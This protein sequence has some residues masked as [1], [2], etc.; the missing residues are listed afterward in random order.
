MKF[1][2]HVIRPI[3][4]ILAIAPMQVFGWGQTGHRVVGQIAENHLNPEA[5]KA[6]KALLGEE[7]LAMCANWMD[8][9]KSNDAYDHMNPW[10]YCTIPDGLSYHT[11]E[12]PDEGDVIQAI[13]HLIV[14]IETKEFQYA[15]NE[16]MAVKMLAHLV[17][18]LH[19]PLHVG[20]GTDKGG[21]DFKIKWFGDYSN[22]HRIW[23]S[24]L[25]NHQQLS[26]TEYAAWIDY[27]NPADVVAWQGSTVIDWAHESQTIRMTIYPEEGASSLGYGYNYE[28]IETLNQRLL[29]A[30]V[31]LAG[32]LN[33]LYGSSNGHS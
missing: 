9:I 15:E 12:H 31:R 21:N 5:A 22:L 29:Q 18:D 26:Y 32:I 33:A 2:F 19:Q 20:N 6:V 8:H 27:T 23:D 7:S 1:P 10:H 3:L 17:G 16:A 30:G 4:L 13:E 25:I 28:H 14:E 11:C 24:D